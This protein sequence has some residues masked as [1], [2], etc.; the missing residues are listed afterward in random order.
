MTPILMIGRW[1]PAS[2]GGLSA[3]RATRDFVHAK[4]ANARRLV[5]E[6]F[7]WPSIAARILAAY[8]SYCP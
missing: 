4:G 5:E 7:Q 1:R 8:C 6:R 2:S 3:P